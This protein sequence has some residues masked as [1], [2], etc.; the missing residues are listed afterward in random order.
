[1]K[2]TKISAF[3][4][5]L[6]ILL[7]TLTACGGLQ[8][9]PDG[10]TLEI[11]L[12]NSYRSEQILEDEDVTIQMSS[13]NTI[14]YQQYEASARE[15][16]LFRYDL[17][18]GEKQEFAVPFEKNAE[19][20]R[21]VS[22][23]TI[24]PYGDGG[25]AVLFNKHST[26]LNYSG[27]TDVE[28][29]VEYYDK[30][31]NLV[32]TVAIPEGFSQDTPVWSERIC[33][34][35]DGNWY[36]FSYENPDQGMNPKLEAYNSK[37]QKY[38]TISLPAGSELHNLITGAD[39]NA[40]AIF[41]VGE[42]GSWLQ[43]VKLSAEDKSYEDIGRPLTNPNMGFAVAGAGE[44]DFFYSDEYAIYGWNDG[45]STE[46][47][48]WVNSDFD[49]VYYLYPVLDDQF[50]VHV[51]PMGSR[52]ETWLLEK[53]TQEE[54]DNTQCISLAV[55]NLPQSLKQAVMDYNRTADGYRIMIKDYGMYNSDENDWKGG[56][57]LFRQDMLDGIVADIICADEMRFDSLASKGLFADWYDFMED[58]K[59]FHK[60]D[61]LTNFFEAYET[62]GRLQRL[63]TSFTVITA[64]A[65][66]EYAGKEQGITVSE[67]MALRDTLPEGMELYGLYNK[68]WMIQNYFCNT[69]NSFVNRKTGECH[70]DTPEFAA[71]LEML[72]DYPEMG[73]AGLRAVQNDEILLYEY[74]FRQPIGYH[75]L[76]SVVFKED[77]MTLLGYPIPENMEGNGGIFQTDY[78]ISVN[79]ESKYQEIVWDFVK[80]MLSEDYQ[81]K[82]TDSMPIHRAS[83]EEDMLTATK[84]SLQMM[85]FES[86][87]VN[88]GNATEEEMAAFYD[89]VQNIRTCWYYDEAVYNILWEEMQMVL[90]GDQTPEEAAKMIQS[91]ASIY[92]SEQS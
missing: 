21:A 28:H 10:A 60:D 65:K 15:S 62:N 63:G 54:I 37:F 14:V 71:I 40:Y 88:V 7:T 23:G 35:A 25:Y 34:D 58:D 9:E 19:S 79:S 17:E 22:L 46:V 83:L 75:A 32:E 16:N 11:D 30:D 41:R 50:V 27:D 76:K 20:G 8:K 29:T 85:Y 66:S 12:S 78:T 57:E 24:E 3:T 90:A 42:Y 74:A 33:T 43:P 68:E 56:M 6:S 72:R 38:G 44:Y 87:E 70:F 91:R 53:R 73:A 55:H 47:V 59:E 5:A 52:M 39:G 48:N 92:L 51:L 67:L 86:G 61:Y 84:Q 13:G 36:V 2:L 1:M 45:E 81:K 80:H 89:Y 64:A 26:S 49:D 69:Q 31:L 77:D 82:L 4:S 18:T